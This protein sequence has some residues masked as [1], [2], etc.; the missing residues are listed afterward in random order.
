[1]AAKI[2]RVH[3]GAVERVERHIAPPMRYACTIPID[4]FDSD[5]KPMDGVVVYVSSSPFA[6]GNTPKPSQV[7]EIAREVVRRL[8]GDAL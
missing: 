1:M 4:V 2:V 5:G 6:L 8:K 3:D 7:A